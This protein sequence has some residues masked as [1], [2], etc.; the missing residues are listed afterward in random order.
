MKGRVAL[1]TFFGDRRTGVRLKQQVHFPATSVRLL[2]DPPQR[3]VIERLA[4]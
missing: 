1:W 3:L 4:A 2:Y